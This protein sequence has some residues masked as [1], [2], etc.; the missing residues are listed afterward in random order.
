ML[1]GELAEL[2]FKQAEVPKQEPT[3]QT[4]VL[5]QLRQAKS[6]SDAKRYGLKHKLLQ[7]LMRQA[8]GEWVVD[9]PGVHHPGV[10]HV[11]TGFRLHTNRRTIPSEV[12]QAETPDYIRAFNAT[13]LQPGDSW[14]TVAKNYLNAYRQKFRDIQSTRRYIDNRLLVGNPNA[15]AIKLQRLIDPPPTNPIDA[16]VSKFAASESSSQLPSVGG[17]LGTI[18]GVPAGAFAGLTGGQ[19]SHYY[20]RTGSL[21]KAWRK[22][23]APVRYQPPF[24][25]RGYYSLPAATRAKLFRAYQAR[26]RGPIDRGFGVL[27]LIGRSAIGLALGGATGGV[28]GYLAGDSLSKSAAEGNYSTEG[29]A[30]GGAIGA[31]PPLIRLLQYLGYELPGYYRAIE[32]APELARRRPDGSWSKSTAHLNRALRPGDVGI[33]G[34]YDDFKFDPEVPTDYILGAGAG[35]AGGGPAVHGISIAHHAQRGPNKGKPVLLHGGMYTPTTVYSDAHAEFEGLKTRWERFKADLASPKT[36]WSAIQRALR[37]EGRIKR[38]VT[39]LKNYAH[40]FL[41]YATGKAR[42]L[43][44]SALETPAKHVGK[45]TKY[46]RPWMFL[47]PKDDLSPLQ[48]KVMKSQILKDA[49]VPYDFAGASTAA[50][51]SV[52]VPRMDW[53]TSKDTQL[54]SLPRC[55]SGHCGSVPARMLQSIGLSPAAKS[56]NQLP[57][58]LLLNPNLKPV[59]VFRKDQMLKSLRGAAIGRT[60]FGLGAAGLTGLAGAVP[61]WV[62]GRLVPKKD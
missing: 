17:L 20:Q 22:M 40:R 33:A 4:V 26:L 47:R 45:Y 39:G 53:F 43:N 3:D 52:F 5:D 16:V 32:S 37:R 36:R 34:W 11:P 24:Q 10:T 58:E 49:P 28:G 44:Q 15:N 48:Q 18:A 55:E 31:A 9:Q 25:M 7:R 50:L 54:K 57:G 2:G 42:L 12:K 13:P 27:D 61:G 21:P 62:A 35:Y 29:A 14:R 46:D 38:E 23:T 19:L 6:H 56:T 60:L 30:T 59:G 41:N 8:P 51:K 1:E